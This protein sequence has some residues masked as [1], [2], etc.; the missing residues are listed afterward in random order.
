MNLKKITQFKKIKQ[1]IET[2]ISIET[3]RLM[4]EAELME[5]KPFW[6]LIKQL[7]ER[8]EKDERIDHAIH[9]FFCYANLTL[10]ESLSF[11]RTY[12]KKVR[13]MSDDFGLWT[14]LGKSLYLSDDGW[15]D[16]TDYFPIN[17]EKA[18]NKVMSHNI[19]EN[20][21][22][23]NTEHECYIRSGLEEE[24]SIWLRDEADE[25]EEETPDY[26]EMLEEENRELKNKLYKVMKTLKT[27]KSELDTL[28]C[29]NW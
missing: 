23:M 10:E 19:D 6:K 24:L 16:F 7:K 13:D 3:D 1:S 12:N 20:A 28:T 4:S 14:K 27:T 5:D 17:G 2:K 8:I 25:D 9:N 18:Y 11:V 22:Y 15:Y 21:D 29:M 26:T